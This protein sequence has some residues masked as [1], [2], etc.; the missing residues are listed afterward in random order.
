MKHSLILLIIS[1]L[2]TSLFSQETI[3]TEKV[4]SRQ[5]D[6]EFT[7]EWQYVSTDLYLLNT[8]RF[9][10]LLNII[11]PDGKK[12]RRKNKEYIKNIMVTAQLNGLDELDKITYPLFNFAV[13]KDDKG[14]YQVQTSNPEAIRIV[15]NVPVSSL[16][17][18]I[19]ATIN[20]NVYSD[21]NQPEMFKFVSE[22]LLTISTLTAVSSTDA[23]MKVVGEIGKMMQ[24]EAAGKQYQ[25]ESTIRFYEEQNFDKRFHSIAIY[26][27]EPTYFFRSGFDTVALSQYLDTTTNPVFNKSVFSKI[28]DYKLFPYIVA[29][30]YRS[31][32]KPQISDDV[33][34]EMLKRREVK[35]EDNYKNK[36]ISREIYIQ[37]KSLIDFLKIFAQLQLD[38]TNY[39]LDYK[40]KI[41][42]DYTIELFLTLQDYWKLKNSYK[43]TSKAFAG[44]PLFENEFK[45]L[46]KRYLTKAN[47]KFEGNSALR[48]IREHVETLSYLEE[49]GAN[50]LDSAQTEDFLR[51]LQAVKIPPREYNSEEATITKHWINTLEN[52]QYTTYYL[53]KIN[54][55]SQLPVIEPTYEKV[56]HFNLST[57]NS[58]CELCKVNVQQFVDKFMIN[59]DEYR[60]SEAIKKLTKTVSD[61]QT[62]IFVYT[63]KQ[64]CIVSNLDT[65]NAL[66]SPAVELYIEKINQID[67]KRKKLNTLINNVP[68]FSVAD[69][70]IA[71]TDKINSLEYQIETT[72]NSI[73]TTNPDL[74]DC[75]DVFN[76]PAEKSQELDK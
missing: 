73:C 21:K 41:T 5:S 36:I 30:N 57:V 9:N 61:A 29:V 38:I 33:D 51:K 62:K 52:Q 54:E 25:F 3:E 48:S 50:S 8:N 19:G 35:N 17:D 49:N 7:N 43:I 10:Y 47:L 1:I 59:Y 74:C 56:Q 58:Y 46:Y 42:E 27:F 76:Q 23:A 28:F 72:L 12:K 55:L 45:P 67:E 20:I 63:Q 75:K 13:T 31:K 6:F 14:E 37:E 32:Y 53:P 44:N 60:Y 2:S 68:L 70:V 16:D 22:Q 34:F 18:Y 69:S 26:V 71:Y 39:E 66:K 15:D 11:N 64:S 4:Y 24:D 40:A 65:A